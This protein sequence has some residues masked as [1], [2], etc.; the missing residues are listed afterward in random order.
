MDSDSQ[1]I[2]NPE[3]KSSLLTIYDKIGMSQS[4]DIG[5]QLF[6]DLIMNNIYSTSTMN[7]IISQVGD[8]INSLSPKEKEPYL[9]LL[10]LFFYNPNHQNNQNNQSVNGSIS[11]TLISKSIYY[12][13][14]SPI[15]N[16]LQTF[17]NEFNEILY[18]I[19]SNVY[20][21]I[22]QYTMPTDISAS[23]RQLNPEEKKAYDILQGF[24]IYNMKY[25]DK[26]NRIVGSL[27]LTKL[28]ENCPIVL[29]PQYT[30]F[31]WDNINNFIDKKNFNAKTELL[32]CLISLILGT[33]NLFCPYA[34]VTLY[35]VL[36]F[37]TDNDW[38]K[39]K[40]ALNV[41]YT[42]IFYCKDEILPL[43]EHIINFLRVL[44][45]DKV[46]EVREVCLLILKIFSENE[47]NKEKKVENNYSD[48][49]N[50]K[51]IN[52][53]NNI[54]INN[55]I[56]NEQSGSIDN[57]KDINDFQESG[58][59]QS[60][61][62]ANKNK[63]YDLNKIEIENHRNK[64]P[65]NKIKKNQ[66]EEKN[67]SNNTNINNGTNLGNNYNINHKFVNRNDD[68]TFVNEKMKIRTDP[69]KS[70]FRTSPN[71]AF[72][73]QAKNN[74][75]DIIV[76]AK[77]EPIKYNYNDKVEYQGPKD[78][79]NQN[80]NKFEFNP[81]NKAQIIDN[82]NNNNERNEYQNNEINNNLN[83]KEIKEN[84]TKF[85]NK[86]T[87][88]NNNKFKNEIKTKYV[89]NKDRKEIKNN[90]NEN[91]S[92]IAEKNKKVKVDSIMI[93]KLLLQMNDLSVKQLSLIDVMEN[94]QTNATQKIK[95]LND[96]IFSLDSLVDELTNELNE[97]K[98]QNY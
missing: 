96:K 22:I 51:N 3:I 95:D 84:L 9:K 28:V 90:K 81:R 12:I 35:K 94:I 30:K 83:E 73:N 32:N 5:Y 86:E 56:R 54:K 41:I 15:L 38:L 2:S 8:F 21:D 17:I 44:K 67:S 66:V 63:K 65:N 7:F 88:M 77:G 19:I 49:S 92:N 43:K 53:D 85:E 29:Q 93:N 25:D 68:N 47:P 50:Q 26:S 20:A 27:C 58:K 64:T 18:P 10:S 1:I 23:T 33:E 62:R 72:F 14:I 52:N 74:T 34:N 55:N 13:Y 97:L 79:V 31:I 80:K 70:I 11:S 57:G 16:V 82:Q 89:R 4:R 76:M 46:K 61:N 60:A 40:L 69:K 6:I 45:T 42:L 98:N 78:N 39:R 71:S 24:C 48:F 75:N 37:L 91:N 36:D 59:K 87:K